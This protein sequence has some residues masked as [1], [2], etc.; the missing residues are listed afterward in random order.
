[1]FFEDIVKIVSES[2][3]DDDSRHENAYQEG[4][5]FAV[6]GLK[7]TLEEALSWGEYIN[8]RFALELLDSWAKRHNGGYETPDERKAFQDGI[9]FVARELEKVINT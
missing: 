6:Y 7:N 4:I 9:A 2:L 3:F 8:D 5:T 1:M